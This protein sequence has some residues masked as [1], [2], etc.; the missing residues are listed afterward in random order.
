MSRHDVEALKDSLIFNLGSTIMAALENPDV[1][2]IMLNDDK[3]LWIESHTDG[4][5]YVTDIAPEKSRMIVQLVASSL[6]TE[7]TLENPI[8]EGELP[9]DGSRFEGILPPIVSNPVFTIRKKAL[10]IFTLEDYVKSEIMPE[11]VLRI[12]E[13][14]ILG[15]QNILVIGGTGS[16]KTTFVN[17]LIY[18]ISELYPNDRLIIAEDTQE[19]QCK[20]KNRIFMRTSNF[21][22]LNRILRT[23]MRLRPNRILVGEVRGGEALSLLKA[24]NTGHSGGVATVHANSAAEGLTRMEQLIAEVTPAPMQ[25]IIAEA[26]HFLVF[27]GRTPNGRKIKEVAMVKNYEHSKRKYQTETLYYDETY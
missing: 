25:M 12:L 3:K 7:A 2:E 13:D 5:E 8:V 17:A 11:S 18:K 22:N 26:V 23:T 27:I 1:I 16:G 10:K 24:W 19:L 21:V 4:M 9:L 15:Y 6:H 20:S 14:A